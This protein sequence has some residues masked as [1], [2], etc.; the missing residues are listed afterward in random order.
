MKDKLVK[1]GRLALMGLLIAALL[2]LYFT[3]LYKL[4]I[5]DGAAYYE[6]SRNSI[7]TTQTV[8]AARGNILDR[9]G[10]VLVKNRSCNN[11]I[12]NTDELFKEEDPNAVILQMVQIV[13]QFG[14]SYTDELPITKEAPFEYVRNMTAMQRTMLDAYLKDKNLPEDTSAVE[15]IAYMRSRYDIDNNY[16]SEQTRIIAGIRYELN[17]R[18]IIP[19]SDY[20]FVED[21]GIDLITTLKEWDVPAVKDVTSYIREYKTDY[22]AHILGYIAMMNESELGEY[23]ELGYP[24][25][26]LVGKDGVER[27]FESY[28][29]G[30]DGTARYVSTAEGTVVSMMYTK[31]PE[32]GNHV[33]L[34]IDIE[35]QEAAEKALEHFITST[36]EARE[37]TNAELELLGNK[38]DQE[39]QI[40]GGAVVVVDIETGEPLT[41]ASYPSYDLTNFLDN[42]SEIS[43]RE[44]APLFNR[45]LQ[46]AYAPGS[47]FKPVTALACLDDGLINIYT[48]TKC[49]G[50][51][52]KYEWAG[53]SPTCW[54]YGQGLHD[55]ENVSGAIRDSCNYFFYTWGDLLGIDKLETFA[56]RFG[57][58]EGTGIE[59]PEEIGNM[60]NQEN[61]PQKT[62]TEENPDG[63]PWRTG[64]TLQAS[65][66]QSDSLFTP[67][68]LAEY[69]ATLANGGTRYSAS[70]LKSVRSYDYSK[71]LFEREAEVLNTIELDDSYYEAVWSGMRAAASNTTTVVGRVF[72][73]ADYSVAT[74]T[75]TAQLGDDRTNNAAFICFAPA[76]D[77][78]VAVAVVVEKGGAGASV[79]PIA[80]S[81]LDY[82]FSFKDGTTSME[83][84]LSLL[85]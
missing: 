85:K 52:T 40:T 12:I 83:T 53:Y 59:L 72:E 54:I 8:T 63:E 1:P 10:R 50:I 49:E 16:D 79:S 42:Y 48:T 84:E 45:S 17:I 34:T 33:Q 27:Q 4:Q 37:L 7:V 11:L 39:E 82:Y 25:N 66:G 43:S 23:E 24:R 62:A 70:I 57:L 61:H 38:K 46:G 80:K 44:N 21:V 41:I 2:I 28:L 5:I 74:K 6:Q 22:A 29:H 64:D 76:D 26:A 69:A 15:L 81:V 47:T 75:G 18:Y 30:S 73:Y 71:K 67:L 32:P 77:P 3:V 78:Q 9:Y 65:I 13:S 56:R 36:N 14:E 35:L 60:A 68:Q 51:F 31:E 55:N 19:T 20:I 58:G